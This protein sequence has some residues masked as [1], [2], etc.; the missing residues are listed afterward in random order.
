MAG[1][2][3][4][5][6]NSLVHSS[7]RP[8]CDMPSS[9]PRA[10]SAATSARGCR[11]RSCRSTGPTPTS[12]SPTNSRATLAELRPDVVVNCAAYNFVD[13]AETEPDAAFAVNA[14]G[15]RDLAGV[16]RDLGCVLVH[17]STDYV[18]GLDAARTTP[19]RGR[20]TPRARSASTA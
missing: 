12:P 6:T 8:L 2:H 20:P 4:D 18:F 1:R 3:R 13:K 19:Y 16:C 11:A 10:S 9:A 17:F 14:W 7:E 5:L 15:V